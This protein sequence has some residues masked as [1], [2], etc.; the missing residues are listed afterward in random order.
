MGTPSPPPPKKKERKSSS[1]TVVDFP[2]GVQLTDVTHRGVLQLPYPDFVE[3]ANV[4]IS[5]TVLRIRL[6][7][8]PS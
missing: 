3:N 8:G 4:V 1:L 6:P 7:S 2:S 5:R